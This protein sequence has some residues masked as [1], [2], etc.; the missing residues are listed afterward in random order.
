MEAQEISLRELIEILLKNK[1]IIA[2][3]TIVCV[4]ISGIFSFLSWIQ[5]MKPRQNLLF[6][7]L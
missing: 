7:T 2:V 4:F 3:I 6:L 1:A 5:Y